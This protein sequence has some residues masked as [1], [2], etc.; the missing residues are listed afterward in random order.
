[1]AFSVADGA[2]LGSAELLESGSEARCNSG[3][4]RSIQAED[5]KR[6]RGTV[7]RREFPSYAQDLRHAIRGQGKGSQGHTS[8]TQARGSIRHLAALSEVHSASVRAAAVALESELLG[9]TSESI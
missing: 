8:P 2:P 1:M 5:A 9:Q 7:D 4:G 6:R 3:A